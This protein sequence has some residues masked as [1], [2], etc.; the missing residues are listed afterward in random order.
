MAQRGFEPTALGVSQATQQILRYHGEG[1]APARSARVGGAWRAAGRGCGRWDRWGGTRQEGSGQNGVRGI[2]GHG[3]GVVEAKGKRHP[4]EQTAFRVVC[5]IGWLIGWGSPFWGNL[6]SG[7]SFTCALRA[8]KP[9]LLMVTLLGLLGPNR[10]LALARG[11][12]SD[13]WLAGN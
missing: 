13:A 1:K 10:W 9:A 4:F 7:S 11:P 8:A 3:L 12:R 2:Y 6:H 5:W